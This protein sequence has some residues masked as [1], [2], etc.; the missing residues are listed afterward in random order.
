MNIPKEVQEDMREVI[1]N[2]DKLNDDTQYSIIGLT[3]FM[4]IEKGIELYTGLPAMQVLDDDSQGALDK[5]GL[6]MLPGKF[7]D[8]IKEIAEA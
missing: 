3:E 8:S 6:G 7:I 4:G 1:I 2:W 5:V